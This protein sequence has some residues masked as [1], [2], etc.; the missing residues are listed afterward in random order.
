MMTGGLWDG[1]WMGGHGGMWMPL[2]LVVVLVAL[3]VW[4]IRRK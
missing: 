2:L 3:A 4:I 1:A